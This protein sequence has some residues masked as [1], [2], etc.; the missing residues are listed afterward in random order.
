MRAAFLSDALAGSNKLLAD[1]P[2]AAE[3]ACERHAEGRPIH[4]PP[5]PLR[6]LRNS[7]CARHWRR[8][9]SGRE[10]GARPFPTFFGGRRRSGREC[11]KCSALLP[12]TATAAT[13]RRA[14]T[15][16]RAIRRR[17]RR[18]SERATSAAAA[19]APSRTAAPTRA[20][21]RRRSERASSP[22]RRAAPGPPSGKRERLP[23]VGAPPLVGALHVGRLLL[24]FV[25][26]LA[27]SLASFGGVSAR[28]PRIAAR[29][30]AAAAIGA[31]KVVPRRE[32]RPA[33]FAGAASGYMLPAL[34]LLPLPP[35][36]AAAAS[37]ARAGPIVAQRR[38]RRLTRARNVSRPTEAT[39]FA[40]IR[41]AR[42]SC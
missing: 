21:R 29:R 27:R 19:G 1:R 41:R 23:P 3:T 35:R 6:L 36:A 31:A 13:T 42:Q 37:S 17:Q 18:A 30:G 20:R 24:A 34:L 26:S 9:P 8:R 39:Q 10:L 22:T 15:A 12:G 2:A 5:P 16:L 32:G 14:K 4:E 11:N 7:F 40:T 38:E 28:A 25:V 33:R